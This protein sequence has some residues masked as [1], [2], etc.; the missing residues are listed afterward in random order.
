MIN[1]TY[2]LWLGDPLASRPVVALWYAFKRG[3]CGLSVIFIRRNVEVLPIEVVLLFA[4][5]MV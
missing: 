3:L 4:V 5:G 2:C 1:E